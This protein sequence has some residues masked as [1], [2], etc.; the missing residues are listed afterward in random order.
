MENTKEWYKS[1]T[2]ISS[3]ITAL[4]GIATAFGLIKGI[5]VD[6]NTIADNIVGIVI[7]VTSLIAVWS[8]IT[9]KKE[10]K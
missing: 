4:I 2:V 1:K 10:I 3:L 6:V 9:A 7:A 8:R 5:D